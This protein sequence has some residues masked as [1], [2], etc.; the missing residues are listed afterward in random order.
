MEIAWL[1]YVVDVRPNANPPA[2]KETARSPTA[3]PD[4]SATCE[5]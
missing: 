5:P 2:V 3:I 1:P 4:V